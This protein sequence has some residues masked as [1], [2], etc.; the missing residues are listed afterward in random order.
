MADATPASEAPEAEQVEPQT[1][2]APAQDTPENPAPADVADDLDALP[3]WAQKE[4]KNLRAEA[5]A[6]R[7]KNNELLQKLAEAGDPKETQRLVEELQAELHRSQRAALVNELARKHNI[8]EAAIP[9]LTATEAQ[10]LEAQVL[11]IAA[12]SQGRGPA[13]PPPL[14]PSGGRD[15]MAAPPVDPLEL[16]KKAKSRVK[17]FG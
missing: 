3:D 11:A 4:I 12:L 13:T 9:L 8:P 10:E 2:E 5:A 14:N 17:T 6:K 15:P 7:I 1:E 16:Y